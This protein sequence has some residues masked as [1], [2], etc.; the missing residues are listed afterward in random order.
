MLMLGLNPKTSEKTVGF[1]LSSYRKGSVAVGPI[2][3]LIHLP[4]NMVQGALAFQ[5]YIRSSNLDP[6][7]PETH[8]GCWKQLTVRTTCDGQLMLVVL[9]NSI[10][11]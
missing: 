9:I 5:E 2:E 11:S 6:H 8:S 10:V 7:D 1:R 3:H 4:K